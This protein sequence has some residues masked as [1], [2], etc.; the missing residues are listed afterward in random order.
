MEKSESDIY[1]SRH[2]ARDIIRNSCNARELDAVIFTG[3]GTTGAVHK[4]IKSLKLDSPT[5]FVGPNEHHSNL[6]PWRE[7]GASVVN[8]RPNQHGQADL[9]HLETELKAHQGIGD[10]LVGCFTAASNVTGVMED[11]LAVTSLLH[12]Y[13]ALSFW[14]YATA[15][16]YVNIDVNPKV[17]SDPSG[18][19]YKDAIYFSMHKFLGG[20]QTP[21]VLI[22]KKCLFQNSSPEGAGGGSVFYVTESDHRYL[23]EPEVR[24]EGGTPAI[25]ESVRAGLVMK[26]K[27]SVGVEFIMTREELLRQRFVKRFENNENLLILGP[28]SSSQLAVFSFLVRA[29][30]SGLY[31]HHN[32]VVALLNDLFG[33]QARGGCACAGPLMQSLLGLNRELVRNY[34]AVLVEDERLDRV[35]PRTDFDGGRKA[36]TGQTQ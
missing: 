15:A 5:V 28:S 24:E 30:G 21:G 3:S 19:C 23:Q 26:L 12:K 34:E 4:L 2:E 7:I 6:L 14:D 8:I 1:I 32:F 16:P 25:V 31:L 22:A 9:Q 33:I 36:A 29:G 20:V 35:G 10:V 17:A 13:G 18:L 27:Q 11:D